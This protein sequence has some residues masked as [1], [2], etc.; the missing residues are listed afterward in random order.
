MS[1]RSLVLRA[2]TGQS[3]LVTDGATPADFEVAEQAL[4]ARF[5]ADHRTLLAK[6]NG[7]ERWF[8]GCFLMVYSTEVLVR[9][10]REIEGHP[11]F[12][13]F[14]SDGSRELIGFDM[15]SPSPPVVMI[16]ITSAGWEDALL[17][18]ESLADFMQQLASEEDYRWDEPYRPSA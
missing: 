11:G 3:A 18:A 17:Q 16:D 4:G 7:W 13:A 5:L 1:V 12:L 2:T 14:A 15:R 6:E 10:N 9:V 8:G